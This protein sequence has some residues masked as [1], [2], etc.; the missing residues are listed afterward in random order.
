M[1][2]WAS[3]PKKKKRNPSHLTN[4]S[5]VLQ[6]LFAD[7]KSPLS[8]QFIK[9]KLIKG[10]QQIGGDMVASS[11]LPVTYRY[12]RLVIWVKSSTRLQELR[13]MEATLLENINEFLGSAMVKELRFTLEDRRGVQASSLPDKIFSPNSG[14]DDDGSGSSRF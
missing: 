4:M 2:D 8:D 14:N 1:G 13:Y 10:W 3:K 6:S 9:F 7:G 11:C 12:G 5:S